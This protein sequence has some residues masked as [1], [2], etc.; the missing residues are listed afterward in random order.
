MLVNKTGSRP[1][2]AG[3]FLPSAR[4]GVLVLLVGW[5]LIVM[6]LTPYNHG[7]Y[8]L[9]LPQN[10][11]AWMIAWSV[12]GWVSV[13]LPAALPL[14]VTPAWWTVVAGA[15]LMTLPVLW[16]PS[17]DWPE[18]GLPRL[19]GLCSGVLFLLAL[20]QCRLKPRH[21]T[22]LMA[23]IATA[24]ATEAVVVILGLFYPSVLSSLSQGIPFPLRTRRSR[25][26]SAGQRHGQLSEFWPGVT[27]DV[28]GSQR[29]AAL[30]PLRGA[31]PAGI[32][33]CFHRADL[34]RPHSAAV[35]HRVAGRCGGGG[36]RPGS[37]FRPEIYR[38]DNLPSPS[39]PGGT[40]PAGVCARDIVAEYFTGFSP[41]GP[42]LILP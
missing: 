13:C 40:P 25:G 10:L 41:G 33:F 24:A 34:L 4:I 9:D 39:G 18:A 11:L 20:L 38:P 12:T 36:G 17:A 31:G 1:D 30:V 14:R 6:H 8:G 26:V 28:T 7:G 29:G 2:C 21:I 15:G 16:A 32:A 5:L 3:N 19:L 35:P 42:F 27:A 22:C 37:L 23:V